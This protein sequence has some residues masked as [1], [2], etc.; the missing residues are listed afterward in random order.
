[1]TSPTGTN[2]ISAPLSARAMAIAFLVPLV[3]PVISAV[4]PFMEKMES[5]DAA[6]LVFILLA[7]RLS[8]V[9]G[10]MEDA[11]VFG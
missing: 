7:K 6:I 5:I 4:C 11:N 3:P 8:F 10:E 9:P 1:M 2:R